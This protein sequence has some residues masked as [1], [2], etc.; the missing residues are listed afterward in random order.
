M[1]VLDASALVEQLLD[2]SKGLQ[3]QDRCLGKAD[4][5]HSPH[6]V[7]LEVTQVL[8]RYCQHGQLSTIRAYQAIEDL[9]VFPLTRY[10]H[11]FFLP[12]IWELRENLSSYDAAYVALAELLDAPLVTCDTRLG[13]APGHSAIVEV[14]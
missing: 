5:I 6:L 1:I 13:S 11:E 4:T 8:R 12:R 14:F 7:D 3:L 2:T 9:L 10:A